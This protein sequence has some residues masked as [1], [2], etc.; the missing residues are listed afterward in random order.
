[1]SIVQFDSTIY[2]IRGSS[3]TCSLLQ[4]R[5]IATK[6]TNATVHLDR[7][8]IVFESKGNDLSV[9]WSTYCKQVLPSNTFS[10]KVVVVV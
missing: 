3:L 4:R 5:H 10:T 8:I 7:L 2:N 9:A 1:M 6:S